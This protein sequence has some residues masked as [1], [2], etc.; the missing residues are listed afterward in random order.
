MSDLLEQV[1]KDFEQVK[2]VAEKN[3]KNVLL[4][5]MMPKIKDWID[6]QIIEGNDIDNLGEKQQLLH[7]EDDDELESS[8]DDDENDDEQ[9]TDG[10]KCEAVLDLKSME[11]ELFPDAN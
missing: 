1:L 3:A 11:A 5:K 2:E 6:Q 8:S 4:E 7:D 10:S 9:I